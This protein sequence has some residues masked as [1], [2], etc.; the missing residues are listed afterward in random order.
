MS[1][2]ASNLVLNEGGTLTV[3][4][5]TF[6]FYVTRRSRVQFRAEALG[7]WDVVLSNHPW[8]MPRD[9]ADIETNLI[10]RGEGRNPAVVGAVRIKAWFDSILKVA[11]EKFASETKTSR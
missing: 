1:F 2:S 10:T 9:L 6:R 7:P 4:D 11:N 5:T 8:L 3:G